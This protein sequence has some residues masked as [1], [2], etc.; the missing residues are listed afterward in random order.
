SIQRI[1]MLQGLIIGIVGTTAGAI[2]GLAL[3]S[4]LDRY[5]LIQVPMDVY[6]ISYVPFTLEPLD[7]VVVVLSAVLICFLATI[8]PSRQAAK[9]DP[10]LALRYQ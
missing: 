1:F 4:V 10:A 5:K 3:I 2:A 9:L 7:F 8:Y 6:Q